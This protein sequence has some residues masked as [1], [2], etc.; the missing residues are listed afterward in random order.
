MVLF[1]E[2]NFSPFTKG[3]LVMTAW[4]DFSK[5][6]SV[7]FHQSTC[8]FLF[9]FQAVFWLQLSLNISWKSDTVMPLALFLLRLL[10]YFQSLVFNMSLNVVLFS[11]RELFLVAWL[12]FH[13]VCKLLACYGCLDYI[14]SS[15]PQTWTILPFFCV[16]SFISLFMFCNFPC[17]DLLRPSLVKFLLSY[18]IVIGTDF[19]ISLLAI[20]LFVYAK[21]IGFSLLIL[22]P[23][24]FPNT[25][26]SSSLLVES[27]RFP[28]CIGSCH[29]QM[30][31]LASC[32][33][34]P[35]LSV[36]CLTALATILR[37]ILNSSGDM[38][39]SV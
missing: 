14:N 37:T 34:I 27:C 12:K 33:P 9:L 11:S 4:I 22:Y 1:P 17:R 20:P 8:L 31:N 36:F 6:V 23:V 21:A 19:A 39:S 24:T 15:S 2:I 28:I 26:M 35:L 13:W 38:A 32:F 16:F 5:G 18:A 25:L 29:L 10:C 30:G 3:K 7:L